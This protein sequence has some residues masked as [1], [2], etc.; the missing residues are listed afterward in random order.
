MKA[1]PHRSTTDEYFSIIF[2]ARPAVQSRQRLAPASSRAIAQTE[3]IARFCMKS[4]RRLA[5]QSHLFCNVWPTVHCLVVFSSEI[6]EIHE[7]CTAPLYN[8]W[9]FFNYFLREASSP[10]KTKACTYFQQGRCTKGE[11]CTFLHEEPKEA[12]ETEPSLLQCLAHCT[13]FSYV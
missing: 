11:A 5:K 1:A 10:V 8:R 13:L 7:S 2:C 12:C 4:P 9:I 3:S 6:S